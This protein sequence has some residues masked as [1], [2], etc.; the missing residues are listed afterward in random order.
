MRILL[1]CLAVAFLAANSVF[2]DETLP[3]RQQTKPIALVGGMVHPISG[4]A[5]ENATIVFSEGKIVALGASIDVPADAEVI[6]IDGKHVYPGLFESH[7]QLGLKEYDSIRAS[8]D[9]AEVGSINPNAQA[10][11]ALNPDSSLLPVT[12]SNGVLL[13]L[14][15]PSGGL[16]SGQAAVIQ[17]DGWTYEDLTLDADAAMIVNWPSPAGRGRRGGGRS[18]PTTAT[19]PTDT[20]GELKQLLTNAK[21]YDELRIHQP[22][23]QPVDLRLAALAKVVSREIPLLVAADS[24]GQ[25][26]SAVA[27]AVRENL[28][29]IILGGYDAA[30]CADLLKRH[31]VPVVITAVHRNPL[32]RSDAYDASY[33][34]P[35][36]LQAAGVKFCIS[37]SGRSETWNTRNLPYHAA[38]AVAYGLDAEQAIRAITLSPAEIFQVADR[39]G[40]LEVGKEATLI[41]TDGNPLEIPTQTEIAFVQGRRLDLSNKHTRLRDKYLQKYNETK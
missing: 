4:P 17:L 3:G 2:A 26:E 7:S 22:D 41:V 15:A 30:E 29:L 35:A 39:V 5:I 20:L 32:S 13:A 36:R 38:T 9:E 1:E 21:R 8:I 31:D 11:V 24:L 40:S 14:S 10:A 25:I 23:Q 27:F 12:R 33:T 16:I 37:S 19:A 34:L 28:R 18:G 6:L